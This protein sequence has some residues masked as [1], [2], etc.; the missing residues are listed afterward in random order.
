MPTLIPT[1][2]VPV[3]S[4]DLQCK[5]KPQ[6]AVSQ[7]RFLPIGSPGSAPQNWRIPVCIEYEADGRIRNQCELL[8]DPRATI[9]LSEAHSCPAWT[10]GNYGA[11]GY[12]RVAYS[13]ET[14]KSL[15]HSGIDKLTLP[16][17]IGLLGDVS[18]LVSS[19]DVVESD[20]LALVPRFADSPEREI[21]TTVT[22]IATA[23]VSMQVP[24]EFLPKGRKFIRDMFGDRALK[25]GWKSSPGDSVETR[26]L[27]QSLVSFAASAGE[28][29]PLID[30]ARELARA[31]L[32]DHNAI[33]PAMV[34][35]VLFIAA[36]YGDR[37][38]F[39][40]LVSA[41]D[42]E[43]DHRARQSI[44][45]ALGSFANP[46]LARAGM[47]LFLTGKYDA[48]EAFF[49]LVLGPRNNRGT[50]TLPFEFVTGNLDAILARLPREV[51]E[52][53]A[54][55]LPASGSGFCDAEGHRKVD[56][57]F[58]DR[59][60]DYSGGPRQLAQ[61]LESIDICAALSQTTR[62]SIIEF[63]KKY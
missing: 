37:T 56:E 33:E 40:S 8:S 58:K 14:L 22:G 6:V 2:G 55:T 4:M 24:E 49:N 1:V 29:W 5:D 47:Q 21:V 39:D 25:L 34:S 3:L 31:W 16:E 51:G 38:F 20:A 23:A 17:K 19:G 61:V 11:K 53:F 13:P 32:K 59:V 28:I 57:F 36:R 44:F 52:D 35:S 18:A 27:R 15:L 7:K 42:N 12:Y 50:R 48:R 62:P 54:A 43:K 10:M 63:L 9:R 45:A 60:K 26:L 30:Q 41:L 46:E